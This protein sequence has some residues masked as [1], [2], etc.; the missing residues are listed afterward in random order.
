MDLNSSNNGC[1][2]LGS[3][4]AP[5]S[6][7]VK[8]FVFY[9]Q[10]ENSKP[11]REGGATPLPRRR[12]ETTPRR[13]ATPQLRRAQP[14]LL[15]F[16][17]NPPTEGGGIRKS[18][19]QKNRKTNAALHESYPTGNPAAKSTTRGRIKY[20]GEDPSR[21]SPAARSAPPAT[22]RPAL[23][24]WSIIPKTRRKPKVTHFHISPMPPLSA[25]TSRATHAH[26]TSP[27]S[28]GFCAI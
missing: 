16:R 27:R 8:F 20:C 13:G 6:G 4:V 5:F 24:P 25:L 21:A 18:A 22:H 15:L 1:T 23:T 28:T 2:R 12:I 3:G 10:D 9:H 14:L 17:S 26:P 7:V 19:V 11:P